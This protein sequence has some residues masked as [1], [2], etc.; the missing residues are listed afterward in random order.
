MEGIKICD[1]ALNTPTTDVRVSWP[2]G[3]MAE[4]DVISLQRTLALQP[5]LSFVR[6]VRQIQTTARAGNAARSFCGCWDDRL[7]DTRGAR[8][9]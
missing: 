1:T 6:I 5:A 8:L 4:I 3:C 2:T 7:P 9:F